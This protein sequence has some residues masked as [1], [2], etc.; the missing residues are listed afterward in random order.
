MF[1]MMLENNE[2]DKI[3]RTWILIH[4]EDERLGIVKDGTQNFNVSS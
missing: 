1:A 4:M 2:K 3:N